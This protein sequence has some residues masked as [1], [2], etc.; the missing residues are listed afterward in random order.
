MAQDTAKRP[1]LGH[2]LDSIRPLYN[3]D[4]RRH[5]GSLYDSS[6]SFGSWPFVDPSTSVTEGLPEPTWILDIGRS[7]DCHGMRLHSGLKYLVHTR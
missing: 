3:L 6:R 2:R 5:R 4:A 1:E 7:N